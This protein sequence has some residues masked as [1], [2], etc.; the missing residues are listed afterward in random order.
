MKVYTM[1]DIK[2][3][4]DS[5]P[6]CH[7]EWTATAQLSENDD[8]GLSVTENFHCRTKSEEIAR[9]L[10]Q[11][12]IDGALT[13]SVA[14]GFTYVAAVA[15]VTGSDG[16]VKCTVLGI[17]T[18]LEET[19]QLSTDEVG[20]LLHYVIDKLTCF[21]HSVS[22][23]SDSA[24]CKSCETLEQY[25][26]CEVW[27]PSIAYDM[28][29]YVD[30]ISEIDVKFKH[31]I[32]EIP[33]E[34]ESVT[35]TL[36][37]FRLT[38]QRKLEDMKAQYYM[39]GYET[40]YVLV[41]L[42]FEMAPALSLVKHLLPL[43]KWSILCRHL[44]SYNYSRSESKTVL[45]ENLLQK[46]SEKDKECFD[47]FEKSWKALRSSENVSILSHSCKTLPEM[48]VIN[49]RATVQTAVIENVESVI[50]K[51]LRALAD[52]QNRFLENLLKIAS[53]GNCPAV[54]FVKKCLSGG[55]CLN[56]AAVKCVLLQHA[57]HSQVVT[58]D[59]SKL[60]DELTMFAQNNLSYGRGNEVCYNFTKIE[61]ELANELVLGK[62]HLTMDSTF[63][64]VTYANELFVSSAAVLQDS[65]ALIPQV[66]LGHAVVNGIEERRRNHP[67]Y[68]MKLMRQS[69]VLLCLVKKTGGSKDQTIDSYIQKWQKTL[70]GG[71]NASLLPSSGEPLRLSKHR[72]FVRASRRFPGRHCGRFIERFSEE[73]AFVGFGIG[74]E[75]VQ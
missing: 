70:P 12:I 14:L 62:A 51:V 49:A 72:F 21:H 38:R 71:F 6:L 40:K 69:E 47:D 44:V 7:A 16:D 10:L 74:T 68:V 54:G 60:S 66:P 55:E 4:F 24:I 75:R 36:H 1:R 59:L 63:P 64:V 25:L 45:I 58:C 35:R 20:L 46:K 18:R 52:I 31:E 8:E 48:P 13:C 73:T 29:A 50:Y 39:A 65:M 57:V 37:A 41:G 27:K 19:M 42:F 9:D 61:M 22:F 3:N 11:F 33:C 28:K 30:S 34:A 5:C 17:W 15:S 23:D 56:I 43:L 67:D 32:L 53:S 26:I 2:A